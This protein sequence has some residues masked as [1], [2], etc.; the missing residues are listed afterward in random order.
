MG[1]AQ[2]KAAVAFFSL[3]RVEKMQNDA[4]MRCRKKGHGTPGQR[5]GHAAAWPAAYKKQKIRE[6][7]EWKPDCESYFCL[8][9]FV[10]FCREF[11]CES[12][13]SLLHLHEK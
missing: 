3:R 7:F 6:I 2:P 13:H 4:S 1:G 8:A 12:F 10:L 11:Y 9:Q 5:G